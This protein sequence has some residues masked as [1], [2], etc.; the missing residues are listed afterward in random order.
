MPAGKREHSSL[1]KKKIK[2]SVHHLGCV[3]WQISRK[4]LILLTSGKEWNKVFHSQFWF[5]LLFFLSSPLP[6]LP[7]PPS[8]CSPLSLCTICSSL[9][10]WKMKVIHPRKVPE[11]CISLCY[12]VLHHSNKIPR[13]KTSEDL[14]WLMASGVLILCHWIHCYETVG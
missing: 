3:M 13:K 5:F 10:W 8:L 1:T 4:Q 2:G 11:A 6:S 14:F 9:K 12:S 7:L